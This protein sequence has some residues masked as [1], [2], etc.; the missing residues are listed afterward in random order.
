[1]LNL[2]SLNNKFN[3]EEKDGPQEEAELG[4]PE[5]AEIFQLSTEVKHSSTS[6]KSCQ[7]HY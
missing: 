6:E 4:S 7:P 5:E 2:V 1:V 3:S